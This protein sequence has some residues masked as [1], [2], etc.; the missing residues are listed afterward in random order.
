MVALLGIGDSQFYNVE[1]LRQVQI[2]H[3]IVVPEQES[4]DLRLDPFYESFRLV[5]VY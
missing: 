1:Y 3:P 5:V 2:L 4:T